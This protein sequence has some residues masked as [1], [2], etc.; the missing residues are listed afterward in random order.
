MDASHPEK[1]SLFG[2]VDIVRGD[3][4]PTAISSFKEPRSANAGYHPSVV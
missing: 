1:V 2:S 3:L 4:L